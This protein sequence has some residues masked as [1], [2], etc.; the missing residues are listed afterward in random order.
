MCHL[1]TGARIIYL[2]TCFF[3]DCETNHFVGIMLS[4]QYMAFPY[5]VINPGSCKRNEH[6]L[7][8]FYFHLA[9]SDQQSHGTAI[10]AGHPQPEPLGH[11]ANDRK[12]PMASPYGHA[13]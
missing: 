9:L 13:V 11:L 12:A 7:L 3:G 4:Q 2:G 6:T 1:T 8:F 5:F 10:W